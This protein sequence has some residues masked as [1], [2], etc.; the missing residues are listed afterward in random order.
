MLFIAEMHILGTRIMLS[1]FGGTKEA[2]G[3][4]TMEMVAVFENEAGLREA[5][6]VINEGSKTII[7]IGP[8][9]FNECLVSYIDKF[10]VRWCFMV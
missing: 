10:G 5:Y 6:Q 4:S 2:T 8:I 3:D 1:D 9:F 7:P